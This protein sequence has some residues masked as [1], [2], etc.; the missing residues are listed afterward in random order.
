VN[1][2]RFGHERI[3]IN[4]EC[5]GSTIGIAGDRQESLSYK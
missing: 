5:W 1:T 4:G 3:A 2:I